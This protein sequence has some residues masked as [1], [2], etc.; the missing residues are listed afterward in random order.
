MDM[1]RMTQKVREALASAQTLAAKLNHQEVDGEHLLME[2][3]CQEYGLTSR[4]L[5]KMEI[6][7]DVFKARLQQAL[8]Q[9]VKVSGGAT[10]AGKVYIT[11]RIQQLF[12]KA[13]DEMRA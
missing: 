7:L 10:E 3:L 4:L 9:R 5:E 8:S 12:A 6:S 2:L 11:Q 1:N 13:E